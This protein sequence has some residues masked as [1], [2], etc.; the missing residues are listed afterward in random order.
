MNERN[1]AT[2]IRKSRMNEMMK[3]LPKLLKDWCMP[4]TMPRMSIWMFRESWVPAM[5][6][7]MPSRT[8][9]KSSPDGVTYTSVIFRI[10]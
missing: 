4:S 3:P 2:R 1:C 7:W 6:F 10:W 9:P 5:I 8:L